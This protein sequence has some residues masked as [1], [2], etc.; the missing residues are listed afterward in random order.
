MP[1]G[2]AMSE[3]D[4]LWA[5]CLAAPADDT[6]RLVF[7]DRL[8]EAGLERMADVMRGPHGRAW[9]HIAAGV[10]MESRLLR[11][12]FMSQEERE[13]ELAARISDGIDDIF[14]DG[15]AAD[16]FAGTNAAAWA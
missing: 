5:A 8:Q 3:S 11:L 13:E 7:A 12:Q 15:L 1:A 14:H 9:V 10:P 4:L 6:T 16:E 2:E